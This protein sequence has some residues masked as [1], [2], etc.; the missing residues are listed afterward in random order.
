MSSSLGQLSRRGMDVVDL[1]PEQLAEELEVLQVGLV[2]RPDLASHHRADVRGDENLEAVLARHLRAQL[3][4]QV[5]RD[6]IQELR[7]GRTVLHQMRGCS[8]GEAEEQPV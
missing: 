7:R 4:E 2:T 1:L 8:A 5:L 3:R 6:R